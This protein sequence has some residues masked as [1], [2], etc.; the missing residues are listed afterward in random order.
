MAND[1]VLAVKDE[2]KSTPIDDA[3]AK[4]HNEIAAALT[5]WCDGNRR[6]ALRHLGADHLIASLAPNATEE[7]MDNQLCS[8]LLQ[9]ALDQDSELVARAADHCVINEVQCRKTSLA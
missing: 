1:A 6:A 4:G 2:S 5:H 3:R 9:A 7:A 8:G